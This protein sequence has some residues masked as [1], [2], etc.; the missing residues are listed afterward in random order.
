MMLGG[1]EEARAL[2]DSRFDTAECEGQQ[3]RLMR[4]FKYLITVNKLPLSNKKLHLRLFRRQG[5]SHPPSAVGKTL[6]GPSHP[7]RVFG[8][9]VRRPGSWT[10]V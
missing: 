5:E 2:K 3:R 10:G 7:W 6:R 8:I 9:L 4:V 1:G